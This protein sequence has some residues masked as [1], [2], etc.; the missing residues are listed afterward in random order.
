MN[1]TLLARIEQL[2]TLIRELTGRKT[3][4]DAALRHLGRDV[5]PKDLVP[6]EV[7]CAE[8]VTA[9]IRTVLPTFPVIPGTYTLW[10]QLENDPRFRRVSLPAPGVIVLSPTGTQPATSRVRNGHV[11]IYGQGNAIMSNSSATGIFEQNFSTASWQAR[12]GQAGFPIYYYQ[13]VK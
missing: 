13:L 2:R 5:T 8:T 1:A 7:A 3:M 10:R 11:G 12:Y 9:I 4:L 6:D